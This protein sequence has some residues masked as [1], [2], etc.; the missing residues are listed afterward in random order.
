MVRSTLHVLFA[1]GLL[2]LAACAAPSG[3]ATGEEDPIASLE[4]DLRGAPRYTHRTTALLGTY[5]GGGDCPYGSELCEYARIDKEADGSWSISLGLSEYYES[6][7]YKLKPVNGVF[8]FSSA[9]ARITDYD[10][11]Q[12]PGC[13]DYQHISGVLYP[14]RA[15]DT[16]KPSLK[17]TYDIHFAHPDEEDAPSGDVRHKTYFVRQDW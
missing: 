16:W 3:E 4:E 12:D 8:V 7:K 10:D 5:L 11:C 15:G 2:S 13:G 6:P 9:G 14:K 17:V 1:A